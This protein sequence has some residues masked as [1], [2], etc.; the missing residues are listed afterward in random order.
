VRDEG[1]PNRQTA[2]RFRKGMEVF[3]VHEVPIATGVYAVGARIE[4][5]RVNRSATKEVG[6]KRAVIRETRPM[7][8]TERRRR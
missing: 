2:R 3:G 6:D 5:P 8:R 4:G 7:K 1:K